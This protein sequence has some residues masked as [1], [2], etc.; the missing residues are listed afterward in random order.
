MSLPA[1]VSAS[2]KAGTSVS[3]TFKEP[4]LN[5]LNRSS[6]RV[7]PSSIS[8]DVTLRA[9]NISLSFSTSQSPALLLYV[10]SY[11]REYLALLLNKHGEHSDPPLYFFSL[12]NEK[13][14]LFFL[15]LTL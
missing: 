8:S 15:Y 2:F 14:F 10:S 3:Y 13:Y 7:L 4:V 6:N 12:L 5:E 9:E 11:H 1:E